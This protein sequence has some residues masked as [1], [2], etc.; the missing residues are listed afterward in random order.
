[1]ALIGCVLCRFNR[2]QTYVKETMPI[3]EYF[4]RVGKLHTIDATQSPDVVYAAVS[5]LFV[6]WLQ[7]TYAFIKPDA[8]RLNKK[9]EILDKIKA[10]K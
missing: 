3:I 1:M 6:P 4:R 2:F 8:M 10:E 9:Q 7:T 5:K